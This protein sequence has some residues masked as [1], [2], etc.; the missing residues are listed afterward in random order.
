MP[1][2]DVVK[3]LGLSTSTISRLVQQGVLQ[4]AIRG[5]GIRGGMWFR[6]EDIEKYALERELQTGRR[7]A[8]S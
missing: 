4:P 7:E 1:T 6:V 5:G 2:R 8:A 3:R